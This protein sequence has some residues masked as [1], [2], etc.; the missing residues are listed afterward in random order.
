MIE[1]V[2]SI[3]N[4]VSCSSGETTQPKRPQVDLLECQRHHVYKAK[5]RLR[6]ERTRPK[7]ADVDKR[8][9]PKLIRCTHHS[10]KTP[11]QQRNFPA[12][13]KVL[14]SRQESPRNAI[15]YSE[16]PFTFCTLT[17]KDRCLSWI[18]NGTTPTSSPWPDHFPR[19]PTH[20]SSRMNRV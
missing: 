8:P 1:H 9:R 19:V 17:H 18:P 15:G 5:N 20:V 16:E 13:P 10:R 11:T 14:L 3:Q 7:Y 12:A 6:D 2:T 4:R